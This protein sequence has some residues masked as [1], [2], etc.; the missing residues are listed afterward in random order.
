MARTFSPAGADQR[1]VALFLSDQ[2]DTRQAPVVEFATTG[3]VCDAELPGSGGAGDRD[4]RVLRI[5]AAVG[6]EGHG[7]PW[8]RPLR[9]W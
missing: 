2:Y 1:V 5:H 4:E 8:C 9:S 7:R 6:R 3:V